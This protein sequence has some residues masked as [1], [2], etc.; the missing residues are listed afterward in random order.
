VAIAWTLHH[1]LVT[2]AIVRRAQRGG[3]AQG[4]MRA[5]ELRLSDEEVAEINQSLTSQLNLLVLNDPGSAG[6]PA[7]LETVSKL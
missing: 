6:I 3:R 5:G 7:C 4:M 2:G 1:P